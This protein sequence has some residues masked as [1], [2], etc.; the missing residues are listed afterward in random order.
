[1]DLSFWIPV[2]LVL[3]IVTFGLLFAFVEVCDRV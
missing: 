2:L 1:M 3:G